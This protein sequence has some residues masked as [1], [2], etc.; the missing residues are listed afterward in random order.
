M[1][2]SNSASILLPLLGKASSPVSIYCK[3][4]SL[5]PLVDPLRKR[6]QPCPTLME[7]QSVRGNDA[8]DP[9]D[10]GSRDIWLQTWRA[11]RDVDERKI[12]DAKDDINNLPTVVRRL[13]FICFYVLGSLMWS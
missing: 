4:R 7:R 10:D 5:K 9:P 8:A 12:A 11:V 1:A 13:W 3:P 2:R 6:I